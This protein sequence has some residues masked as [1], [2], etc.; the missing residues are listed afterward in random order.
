MSSPDERIRF[1]TSSE[2]RVRLLSAIEDEPA[3][4][5]T[6]AE[7]LPMSRSA[8]QRNLRGFV[9]RG[10]ATRGDE[11]Y[12]C[13]FGGRL[14]LNRYRELV[15]T[16]RLTEE[17]GR[18][19]DSLADAGLALTAD[20][21]E[22]VTITAATPHDPHAPLQR[23]ADRIAELDVTTFRG[24]A[25][26]VSPVL[27]D[28]HQDLLSDADEIE[29]VVDEPAL[30]TSREAYSEAF[31]DA[32]ETESLSLYVHPEPLSFGLSLFDTHAFVGAYDD[33]GQFIA[34]FEDDSER[35]LGRVADVY[36]TY[37]ADAR[38]I[39]AFDVQ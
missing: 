24:I 6:L 34:C 28:A 35:F 29:L 22:S 5:S 10:W 9:D 19:L 30:S 20:D 12:R 8:I 39:E 1:L 11:G 38:P 4:P 21:L 27:N 25:P 2:N 32:L 26:V 15:G 16:V 36:E 37:R 23:Y 13:T 33:T 14:I 31:T 18:F 17:Y 3:R 7:E